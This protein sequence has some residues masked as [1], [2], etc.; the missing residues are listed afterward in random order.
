MTD[1]LFGQDLIDKICQ[2]ESIV[3]L[4]NEKKEMEFEGIID[5]QYIKMHFDR[6]VK[7]SQDFD[8]VKLMGY[9]GNKSRELIVEIVVNNEDNY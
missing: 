5:A 1:N 4:V 7:S 2:F 9:H 8:I 6:V 3:I